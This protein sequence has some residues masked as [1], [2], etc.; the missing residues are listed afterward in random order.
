MAPR[1][2]I[3]DY[4]SGNVRS[5]YNVVS[6]LKYDVSVSNSADVIR[7]SSHII[8]PGVG[9]FGHAMEK[10]KSLIPL[11]VLED[12]VH[13]KKKPFLGI[14]VGMQVLAE[15]GFEHGENAGLGWVKGIVDR[16]DAQGR[17]LP[18]MGWNDVEVKGNP[19]LFKNFGSVR[20]FY[21]VHSYALKP[22]DPALV[23]TETEYGSRFCSSVQK[24]NVIGVQFHPEKS[25]KAGQLLLK[26]FFALS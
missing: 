20:D 9:A 24:D 13:N 25:Q 7:S 3:L 19:P 17:P 23:L 16:V 5:V 15:K 26:N 8:L 6:Y 21:F 12:E 14:C 18:H 22:A 2:C 1:V 11:D 10:I 4:G